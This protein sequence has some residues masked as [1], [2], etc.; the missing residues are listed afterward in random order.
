MEKLIILIAGIIAGIF[1]KRFSKFSTY[2]NHIVFSLLLPYILIT[3]FSSIKFLDSWYL[4]FW[5]VAFVFGM[6][7]IGKLLKFN[8]G[9][10]ALLGTAEGGTIGFA[11]YLLLGNFPIYTWLIIDSGNG[12][13]LFTF[14]YSKVTGKFNLK[15]LFNPLMISLLFGLILN[16]FNIH[17]TSL[18]LI[19]KIQP[20]ASLLL[21]FFISSV[22]GA[23]INLKFSLTIFKEKKFLLFWLVRLVG[24]AMAITLK[25]PLPI[26]IFMMIPP[27]FL[28]PS[29]YKDNQKYE[30]EYATNFIAVGLPI[31]LGLLAIFYFVSRFVNIY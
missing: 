21:L 7:F 29:M 11:Y 26:I 9:Q 4:F 16:F 31:S 2:A 24:L 19:T 17:L 20:R 18:E 14:I 13:S 12:V 25:F 23:G 6:F 3:E 30:R 22:I 10:S 27:S 1:L 28:L 8:T 5:G 15:G